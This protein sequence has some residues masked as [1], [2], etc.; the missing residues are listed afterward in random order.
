MI[1]IVSNM[2]FLPSCGQKCN[3]G[4]AVLILVFLASSARAQD[5]AR[6]SVSDS[7]HRAAETVKFL[8]GAAAGLLIHESG[9]LVL[10]VAF[11]AG[12]RFKGVR[13]G[14]LPFFAIAHDDVSPR[15]DAAIA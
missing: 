9:H 5:P 8:A 2:R 14:P 15:R 11:D 1:A 12:P 7:E 4:A 10:D 3:L 13:F 6:P